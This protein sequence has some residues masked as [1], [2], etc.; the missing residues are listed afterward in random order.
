[1]RPCCTRGTTF[2]AFRFYAGNDL[3]LCA[4]YPMGCAGFGHMPRYYLRVRVGDALIEDDVGDELGSLQEAEHFASR[5]A[6]ELAED[7]G[8]EGGEVILADAAGTEL[9]RLP[10]KRA[11]H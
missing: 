8:Y 2:R 7:I 3:A 5:M 10:M 9:L 11:T 1:V 6:R 4:V